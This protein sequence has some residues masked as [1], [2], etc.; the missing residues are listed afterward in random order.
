MDDGRG[1]W[2]SYDGGDLEEEKYEE[3]DDGLELEREK[4]SPPEHVPP[5][6]DGGGAEAPPEEETHKGLHP[7]EDIDLAPPE[8]VNLIFACGIRDDKAATVLEAIQ[9][10]VL[11]CQA[12][13]IPIL[14]FHSDRGMEFQARATKQWL[15]GQGIR[16]TTSEAGVHQTN[17]AAES[18]VRWVKLRARTLL[19]SAGLT[20]TSMAHSSINCGNN[21]ARRCSGI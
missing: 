10:V 5:K 21:T 4:G 2:A 16:V 20:P 7:E 18:T 8:L 9:D 13:N 14:R 15:K 3:K 11:Y 19:L 1:A 6:D 12:L 17:G